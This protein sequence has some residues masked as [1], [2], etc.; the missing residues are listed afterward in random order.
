MC[1]Q[2]ICQLTLHVHGCSFVM[3][4]CV[5]VPAEGVPAETI[6]IWSGVYS[7]GFSIGGSIVGGYIAKKM[8]LLHAV[9]FTLAVRIVPQMLRLWVATSELPWN[10]PGATSA[11][12]LAMCSEAFAGGV[13]S[14]CFFAWMMSLVNKKM[15]ASHFAALTTLEVIGKS[16]A[17]TFSGVLADV[18]AIL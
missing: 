17:S 5:I 10:D 1:S 12:L 2:T 3:T 13:L 6:S 4:F 16:V 9:S 8:P 15:G 18:R 11:V 14:T 7:M